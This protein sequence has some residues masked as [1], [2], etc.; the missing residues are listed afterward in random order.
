MSKRKVILTCAVT[1]NAPVN[2]K[3]PYE[4]PVTPK[5]ICNTVIE[6]A[7]AG[8]SIAH[9]H[10]RDPETGEG[11]R[12]VGLFKETV[13]RIRDSG[14]NIVLNLTA[15]MGALFLPDPE[16][17]AQALP[18]SDML[19][20]EDRLE[21]V[22][23]CLPEIASLDIT[24]GNQ[25]EGPFEFVYLNTTR[26]LRQMARLFQEYGVKPELE[27][28]QAGDVL[29]GNQL[30]EEGLI[31]GIPMY[32]FVLG[33]K[34][35]SPATPDTMAYLKSLLPQNVNWCGFGI[36]RQQM[37]M[38]AQSILMGGNVRIGLEDNLYMERGVFATNGALTERA[39]SIIENLGA[40]VATP[41]EARDILGLK[42]VAS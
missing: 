2:P 11:S 32:Q 22:K 33:V 40:S 20:A 36:G 3:Y 12:D 35:A 26:T 17:E 19:N 18:G 7:Q 4:Y 13:S 31:D 41:D 6:A 16:N 14:V 29:F 37:P 25:E 38:A 34:W 23:D 27:A 10:V 30:V 8:A 1:G 42:A 21:H 9:I 15:G 24:T 28:F 39:C 5:Q